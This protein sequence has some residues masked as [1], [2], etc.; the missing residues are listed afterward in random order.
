M[1]IT[2]KIC[3]YAPAKT[4]V[5]KV[6]WRAALRGLCATLCVV[7]CSMLATKAVAAEPKQYTISNVPNVRLSDARQYVSDPSKLLSATAC[8][9][10][11]SKLARL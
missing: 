10:I 3:G 1:H 9:S 6:A 2:V 5:H 8:D 4:S 11:N 7:L